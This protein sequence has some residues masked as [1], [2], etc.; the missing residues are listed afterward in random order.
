MNASEISSVQ[1][2]FHSVK[3][4]PLLIRYNDAKKRLL[5]RCQ[6][7]IDIVSFFESFLIE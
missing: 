4:F 5:F 3:H 2:Y 6:D 1:Y 7:S